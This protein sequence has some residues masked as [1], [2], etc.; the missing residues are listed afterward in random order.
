MAFDSWHL[1]QNQFVHEET[2]ME[3]TLELKHMYYI[4]TEDKH[5]SPDE[6]YPGRIVGRIGSHSAV[7]KRELTAV[8]QGWRRGPEGDLKHTQ[9]N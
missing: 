9:N 4:G 8:A 6:R 2:S 3:W 1:S 7:E 5:R